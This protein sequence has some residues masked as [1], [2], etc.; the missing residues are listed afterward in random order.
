[1]RFVLDTSALISGEDFVDGEFYTTF[2]VLK[3]ARKKGITPQLRSILDVRVRARKP[4]RQFIEMVVAGA[5]KT[6]DVERLSPTDIEIIALAK[7]LDAT[8]LSDDYSI[9]NLAKEMNI[10]YHGILLKEIEQKIYWTYRCTGCLRY[11]DE[12]QESCPICGSKLRTK[13]KKK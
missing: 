4:K 10:P 3:E 12:P 7:E 13:R 1:M 8:I 6:G 9:Q 5:K 11:F 2:S